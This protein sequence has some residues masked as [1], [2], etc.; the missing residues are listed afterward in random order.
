MSE[1]GYI[2]AGEIFISNI[3]RDIYYTI[4]RELGKARVKTA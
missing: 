4:S 2:V 1:Y 3:V